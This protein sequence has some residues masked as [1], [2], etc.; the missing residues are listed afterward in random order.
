MSR[1]SKSYG[2][3]ECKLLGFKAYNKYLKR[4]KPGING[5]QLVLMFGKV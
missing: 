2:F 1:K 4:L 3:I 5:L